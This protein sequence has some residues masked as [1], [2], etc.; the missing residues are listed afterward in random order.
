MKQIL[1][2]G[3][4]ILVLL[5]PIQLQAAEYQKLSLQPGYS[6]VLEVSGVDKFAIGNPEVIQAKLIDSTHLLVNAVGMG[7]TN[8][9]LLDSNSV[10]RKRITVEVSPWQL[11]EVQDYVKYLIGPGVKVIEVNGQVF[12]WG[13]VDEDQDNLSQA[14]TQ[15]FPGVAVRLK[16][17]DRKINIPTLNGLIQQ[18]LN[19]PTLSLKLVKNDLGIL[20]GRV[21]TEQDYNRIEQMLDQLPV[22]VINLVELVLPT[23]NKEHDNILNLIDLLRTLWPSLEFVQKGHLVAIKGELFSEEFQAYQQII[24][25]PVEK[26]NI[27][28]LVTLLPDN[29]PIL[30]EPTL[31]QIRVRLHLLEL[32]RQD[33]SELGFDWDNSIPFKLEGANQGLFQIGS[34]VR[35]GDLMSRLRLLSSKGKVRILAEPELTTLEGKEAQIHVGGEI[36]VS[37]GDGVQW[38]EYGIQFT[39]TPKLAANQDI[40]MKVQAEVSSLD[41]TNQIEL[42]EA[43]LPAISSS[44]FST[45]LCQPSGASSALGG[46]LERRT[47][48]TQSGIPGLANLPMIGELFSWDKTEMTER[49]LVAIV[50]AFIIDDECSDV[51]TKGE[52]ESVNKDRG[53]LL[54]DLGIQ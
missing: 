43:V 19:N 1:H 33:I 21:S 35:D 6:E 17:A 37:D 25:D 30:L 3:M 41:W 31:Q 40:E 27:L 24:K 54:N 44:S 26:G 34:F 45:V 48:R 9:L 46:I 51:L 42:G 39:I 29:K 10:L 13:V 32:N 14:L 4:V 47:G 53:K 12:V 50:S 28:S 7:R 5:L 38:K 15:R 11:R 36:P 20:S 49:E 23:E 52:D 2:I 18:N 8:L 22:R 16:K